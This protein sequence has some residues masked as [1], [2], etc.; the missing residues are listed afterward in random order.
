MKKINNKELAQELSK[1]ISTPIYDTLIELHNADAERRNNGEIA[2]ADTIKTRQ[3]IVS[4][5][6][7][8]LLNR[9]ENYQQFKVLDPSTLDYDYIEDTIRNEYTDGEI[10]IYNYWLWKH[11]PILSDYIDDA[12]SE[13]GITDLKDGGLIKLFQMSEGYFYD[14]F[15]YEVINAL[16]EYHENNE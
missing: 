5:Y 12:I 6:I 4:D 14:N 9:I 2:P 16:K 1:K 15:F 7:E 11:A 3:E 8:D 13:Y 10:E